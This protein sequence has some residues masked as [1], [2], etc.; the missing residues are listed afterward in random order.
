MDDVNG[1]QKLTISTINE[2]SVLDFLSEITSFTE[3]TGAFIMFTNQLTHEPAFL[4]T[5]DYT[6]VLSPSNA[7]DSP[8]SNSAHY[9]ANM[10]AFIL[11][12]KWFNYLRQNGVYDNTRI[13]IVSDH[14]WN[15]DENF[16]YNIELPNGDSL[17]TYNALLMMKDFN[18]SGNIKTD[19]AFMTDADVPF[20]ALDSVVEHPVNPFTHKS[21]E[22]DKSGK[23]FITSSSNLHPTSHFKYSFKINRE[24]WLS[25]QNDIFNI[26]NWRKETVN[27]ENSN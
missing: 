18:I 19:H 22:T 11:L 8:Y 25:V 21:L 4:Q 10:A 23:V 2:Y 14:G 12:G 20:L 5:P 9:H 3:K 7:E 24:E 6:P 16:P 1:D 27:N 13:I 17:E 26:A 15:A